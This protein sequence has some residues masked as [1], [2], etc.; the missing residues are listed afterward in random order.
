MI[1]NILFIS[2][3]VLTAG[4]LH[5]AVPQTDVV[6]AVGVETKRMDREGD[7]EVSDG[8]KHTRDV[9][10]IQTETIDSESPRVYRNEDNIFPYLKWHAADLQSRV[11]SLAADQDLVAVRHYGWR[12]RLFSMFPNVLRVTPV[13]E[14]YTPVPWFF[15]VTL[16]I[17]W[18]GLFF[19][20]WK[21]GRAFTALGE[22][23]SRR[24]RDDDSS[25]GLDDILSDED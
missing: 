5:Y 22:R 15:L 19:L 18:G 6:R 4:F 12:I 20:R 13:A 8:I 23:F 14:P 24:R 16:A 10:F 1:K 17:T 3:L 25:A 21:L 11:Q 9:Y 7:Q 2:V